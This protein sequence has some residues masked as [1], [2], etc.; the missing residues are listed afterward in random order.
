MLPKSFDVP[1]LRER[2]AAY[3]EGAEQITLPNS[4]VEE[5]LDA[6]SIHR[7]FTESE[8]AEFR[9]VCLEG[10]A[11]AFGLRVEFV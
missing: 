2:Y 8:R 3:S 4:R 9:A 1:I 6:G 10:K 11:R 5:F 7:L